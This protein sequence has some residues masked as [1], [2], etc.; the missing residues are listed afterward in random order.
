MEM[1]SVDRR[2]GILGLQVALGRVG[3]DICSARFDPLVLGLLIT[4]FA[5]VAG[6]VLVS[7]AMVTDKATQEWYSQ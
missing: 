5:I 1:K 3:C 6:W 4:V 2:R 7:P